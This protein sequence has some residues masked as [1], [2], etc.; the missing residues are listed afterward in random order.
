MFYP[1]SSLWFSLCG[2]Y[3]LRR[4]VLRY[5]RS[6][7]TNTSELCFSALLPTD[8]LLSMLIKVKSNNLKMHL[9]W[10]Y[11]MRFNRKH[12]FML[13]F[14]TRK[15]FLF[16]SYSEHLLSFEECTKCCTKS[17]VP[18]VMKCVGPWMA[19]CRIPATVLGKTL[20]INASRRRA[21]SGILGPT[22]PGTMCC[23]QPLCV[24]LSSITSIKA[25]VAQN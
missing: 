22:W 11:H 21:K 4:E 19:P 16:A 1:Y 9:G 23:H 20:H 13:R 8:F 25:Q 24:T 14:N 18:Q 15:S 6:Q 7:Q 3:L 5:Q 17:Q 12:V 10:D 2:N